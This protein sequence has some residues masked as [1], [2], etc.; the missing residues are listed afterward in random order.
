M[1]R[2]TVQ[3]PG[4]GSRCVVA[5][6]AEI[7]RALHTLQR[8]FRYCDKFQLLFMLATKSVARLME[9]EALL[10]PS[11]KE[12]VVVV[13]PGTSTSMNPGGGGVCVPVKLAPGSNPD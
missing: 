5:D 13:T 8:A 4:S 6:P 10:D 9:E 7:G 2:P 12:G 11:W 3:G 1:M